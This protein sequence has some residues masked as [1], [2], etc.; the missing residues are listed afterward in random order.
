[1]TRRIHGACL[2]GLLVTSAAGYGWAQRGKPKDAVRATEPAWVVAGKSVPVKIYGQ[3]LA[4]SEIR[5]EAAGVQAKVLK[6]EPYAGKTDDEK[7]RGNSVVEA[8]VTAPATVRP[9]PYPFKL[10]GAGGAEVDG[11]LYLDVDAPEISETEPNNELRK[12]QVLPAGSVTVNG[13]L[14]NEGTDVFRIDGKAGETWRFELFVHRM[15]PT[16]TLEAVMRLRDP[17][18]APVRAAVD[19]GNDCFIEQKLPADGPY[20]LELFDGD[21]RAQADFAYRLAVRKL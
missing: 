8:E 20:L 9:G 17:R 1:V 16:A 19:Y 13:K 15:K 6:V 5:F 3:D 21:N 12:P 14:D 10:I 7:K 4:A 11:K 18:M 2:A